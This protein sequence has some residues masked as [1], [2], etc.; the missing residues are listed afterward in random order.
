[1]LCV[2]DGHLRISRYPVGSQEYRDYLLRS[3]AE[4]IFDTPVMDELKS[5]YGFWESL[6]GRIFVPTRVAQIERLY[7]DGRL[8]DA[9]KKNRNK[10]ANRHVYSGSPMTQRLP[11]L[12]YTTLEVI[13][14]QRVI[15]AVYDYCDQQSILVNLCQGIHD[16][17]MFISNKEIDSNELA[18]IVN[19][20]VGK[21]S[22][23]LLGVILSVSVT[24]CLD[25]RWL[26]RLSPD[27]NGDEKSEGIN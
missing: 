15:A 17:V 20:I 7:N 22:D 23:E 6:N 12:V 14:I 4:R 2:A 24:S 13:M 21:E 16:S 5:I 10:P 9:K 11:T 18:E 8:A 3:F 19:K 26:E 27:S 25:A 1:M